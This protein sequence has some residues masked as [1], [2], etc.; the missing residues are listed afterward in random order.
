MFKEDDEE[1]DVL[2]GSKND[3]PCGL[4]VMKK[5]NP[6][7]SEQ[8]VFKV[9]SLL[10]LDKLAAAKRKKLKEDGEKKKQKYKSDSDSDEED[11]D[12]KKGHERYNEI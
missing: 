10:G 8:H 6:S 4:I 5:K 3:K 7:P 2:E 1:T 12:R 11:L 9:P